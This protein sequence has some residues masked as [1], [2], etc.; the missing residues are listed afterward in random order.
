MKSFVLSCLEVVVFA[1]AFA[2][3]FFFAVAMHKSS[4][5]F[6]LKIETGCYRDFVDNY[7]DKFYGLMIKSN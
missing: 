3:G 4:V 5:V 7:Q 6:A 1:L 2:A